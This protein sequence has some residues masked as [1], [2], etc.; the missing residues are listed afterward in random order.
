MRQDAGM[1]FS[2]NLARIRTEKGLTQEQLAEKIGVQQPTVQRW[3][4]GGRQPRKGYL[5]M[6]AA[7]LEVELAALF[8]EGDASDAF[9]SEAEL[10]R[11]IERAMGELPVG[12]SYADY[13]QAVSSNLH[14]QLMRYQAAG[15]LQDEDEASVL[16]TDAP[17]P[18]PT[19]RSSQAKSHTP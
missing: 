10:A 5:E 9:P 17:P 18:T 13:P 19:K 4:A 7:A 14:A 16:G 8:E 15:G 1:V 6:I 3:E 12:V 11:M 2:A